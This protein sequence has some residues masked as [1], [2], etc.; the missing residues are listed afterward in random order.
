MLGISAKAA[1]N[2][3]K[4]LSVCLCKSSTK[5]FYTSLGLHNVGYHHI[6]PEPFYTSLVLNNAGY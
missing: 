1:P 2:H 3:F 4:L 6:N 5:Q